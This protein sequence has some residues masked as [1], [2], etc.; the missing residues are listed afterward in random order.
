[1]KRLLPM[2]FFLVTH[3]LLSGQQLADRIDSL[4]KADFDQPTGIT[5]LVTQH[6]QTRFDGAYG[7][8]NV[9]L[10]I[11]MHTDDVF[12]LG[13]VTKQFTSSA[14]LRLAE[15][16]KLNIQDDIHKYFPG[17]P[18]E[19]HT[20]TIEHLLTHTSGIPSYTDLP[21]WTPEVHRKD[22]TPDELIEEFKRDTLDFEPGSR[23]KYNNTGYFMLGAIIEKV[24]G[25]TYEDY[26]R[27]QFWEPLGMTH[28]FYGSNSP[29]IPNRIPGYAKQ[30][31]KLINA[32]FLSMT[33]PYAAG[34][35]LSTTGDLAIWNHAVFS[36]QVI[37]AAS[38]KMAHTPYTLTDGSKTN[39]GYGWFIGNKWDERT[40]EHSGGI[41][42]FLTQSKYFP[43]QDLYVVIL[44][45]CNCFAPGALADKIAGLTLGKSLA[46]PVIEISAQTMQDYVG[47]YTLAPGFIITIFIQNDKL[48]AQATNQ[49]ALQLYATKPDLFFIKE[50]E[51]ELEFVRKE[52]KVTEL[53]LHQGGAAQNAPRTK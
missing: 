47:E 4:I 15:Q 27:T 28:T 25:M 29:I 13:S 36:D 49:A 48:M 30:G 10:Q 37:S 7:W 8:A 53:I 24:S 38:R 20:I 3:F 51:A 19:G 32:P 6:G 18:T 2:F 41:H 44:S 33:Q 40:I 31:D 5:V 52:G 9:E 22:F 14:I 1:M 23:F 42:G 12:R 43:D 26:L 50:V 16:G 11:P 17:Y 35:L 34:S 46:K 39:Y 45:N 21:E